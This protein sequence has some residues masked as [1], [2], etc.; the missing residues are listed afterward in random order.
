MDLLR[1]VAVHISLIARGSSVIISAV[2]TVLA[3]AACE[4]RVAEP[5]AGARLY[6]RYC[7][8]CHG[9]TGQGD[10][11]V[12]TSLSQRPTDLTQLRS[13]VP[14]IMRQIDGRR[15]IRAHGPAAMPVWGTV[16]EE[17][18]IDDPHTQRTALL[19]VE[20]LAHYV[21]ELRE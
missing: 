14:E 2:M 20:M 4:R 17:S 1:G 6:V 16:F 9:L 19:Q 8:S 7:A 3:C 10:G 12:A 21:V 11:P 13:P 15:E 5:P 18:L